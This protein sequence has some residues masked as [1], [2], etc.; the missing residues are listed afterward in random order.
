MTLLSPLCVYVIRKLNNFGVWSIVGQNKEFK[1]WHLL[2]S[3][4]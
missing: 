3:K 4:A 1:T 2:N